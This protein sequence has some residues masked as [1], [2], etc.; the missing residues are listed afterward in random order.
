[1]RSYLDPFSL[2]VRFMRENNPGGAINVWKD[3]VQE[4]N[5]NA[6]Y[7]L[8][9]EYAMGR[10]MVQDWERAETLWQAA[11]TQGHL[12]AQEALIQLYTGDDSQ[13][14]CEKKGCPEPAKSEMAYEWALIRAQVLASLDDEERYLA[15]PDTR[16]D[17]VALSEPQ[18]DEAQRAQIQTRVEA[19]SPSPKRC[20]E[21]R[22]DY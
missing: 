13:P 1:M 19:W 20:R 17:W 15:R 10:W 22:G 3:A 11:A 9:V 6:E 16:T 12:Q 18:V 14:L 21:L 4:K 5:C 8:G 2:G 7:A